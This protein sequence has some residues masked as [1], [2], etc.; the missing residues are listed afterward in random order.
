[1][2]TIKTA[3]DAFDP[4]E[5]GIMFA[6]GMV[7]VNPERFLIA[8]NDITDATSGHI[9]GLM[10]QG[11]KVLIDSGIF[12]LTNDH[13]RK[14]GV[15]MD[16]ALALPPDKIDGFDDLY[17]RYVKHMK[18]LG[19]KSWG[20][21]ELDQGGEVNKRKTRAKLH[22]EGLSPIPVYHPLVDSWEYFDE[23]ASEYDRMC[24]GNVVQASTS[25]RRQL[26]HTLWERKRKYPDLFVHV[27][28]ITANE[29][30]VAMPVDSC[31]SSTW[32][33]GLRYP[34]IGLGMGYMRRI[35]SILD[36]RFFYIRDEPTV[37][38]PT[39]ILKPS[40]LE[41][42]KPLADRVY[43]DELTFVNHN[44]AQ[45]VE[46]RNRLFGEERLPAFIEGETPL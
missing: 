21:I 27:L 42:T 30:T 46:D 11:A 23:L 1:M 28:G 16:E 4:D 24:F 41:S 8:I 37:Q 7:R 10:D 17:T 39:T 22:D 34:S 20:Y 45:I 25:T 19:D 40:T 13:K 18:A 14:H 9:A 6:A 35:G 3:G 5:R 36:R 31:D 29:S 38:H 44:W 26:L 32:L 12:N 43:A 15:T 33:N 2:A